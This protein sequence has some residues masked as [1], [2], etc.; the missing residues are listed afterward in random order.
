[1]P[2]YC[3][4]T[5]KTLFSVSAIM[6]LILALT[7]PGRVD[8][9]SVG[10]RDDGV[11]RD[12]ITLRFSPLQWP[13][14][15]VDQIFA[16]ALYNAATQQYSQLWHYLNFRADGTL[17][18]A[19]ETNTGQWIQGNGGYTALLNIGLTG[20]G[21]NMSYTLGAQTF[22]TNFNLKVG[23]RAGA[24]KMI[25][26]FDAAGEMT[27]N[28]TTYQIGMN[29]QA[30][31]HRYNLNSTFLRFECPARSTP[32]GYYL[33]AFELNALAPGNAFRQQ[34]HYINGVSQPNIERSEVGIFRLNGSDVT[35]DFTV[36]PNTP[37]IGAFSDFNEFHAE[38]VTTNGQLQ[39]IVDEFSAGNNVCHYVP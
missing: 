29:C 27:E 34:D 8:A 13:T 5:D 10:F 9:Q 39:L 1:M 6:L 18:L 32:T 22:Q 23:H 12:A 25:R 24:L 20:Y 17:E 33:D 4:V 35:I 36:N 19:I 7:S 30:F 2:R 16:C 11:L 31:G 26:Y 21:I 38:L 14:I 37:G 3:R 15:P 28:G